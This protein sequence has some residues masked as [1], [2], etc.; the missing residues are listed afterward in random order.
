[1]KKTRNRK[2]IPATKLVEKALTVM[3]YQD[4][5]DLCGVSKGSVKRWKAVNKADLEK[6]RPLMKT[7]Q[8]A[9]FRTNEEI[10]E[11]LRKVYTMHTDIVMMVKLSHMRQLAG[12]AIY[13]TRR[14]KSFRKYCDEQDFVFVEAASFDFEGFIFASLENLTLIAKEKAEFFKHKFLKWEDPC[15][16]SSK[17]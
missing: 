5:A 13:S 10:F 7:F 1:M 4:I 17:G 12:V 11:I 2:T 6:I 16:N 9:V 15:G 3:S 14:S 8:N